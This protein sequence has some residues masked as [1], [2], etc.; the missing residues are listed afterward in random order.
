M[1]KYISLLL[2]ILFAGCSSKPE[3]IKNPQMLAL[4]NISV[5]L[6]IGGV[7]T[8]GSYQDKFL[9]KAPRDVY[10]NSFFIDKT[11]VT[12]AA[13]KQYL[14]ET[15]G[16]VRPLPHLEDPILGADKLPVVNV[17]HKE[18][19]DFCKFYNKRLP[20]EAEWEYAAKGN[21]KKTKY[22][23]G[24]DEDPIYMNYRGSKKFISVPVGSYAS[25]EYGLYDMN[26][27]VRE[28]VEDSYQKDF[29]NKPCTEPDLADLAGDIYDG[30]KGLFVK[31]K[32][33]EHNCYINPLNTADVIYKSNRGGSFEYSKG[34][35]ATISFRFF[36]EKESMH[37]DLGF[38]CVA[39]ESI[40]NEK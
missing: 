7:Y 21:T 35:P 34:Y 4:N 29:Y 31:S 6:I 19:Q 23:W 22:Y 13:Y 14:I 12:N 37:N 28:W 9:D 25:N 16:R 20:T 2:I 40:K 1:R 8:M 32:F 36:D 38:R 5:S 3:I 30:V 15:G 33:V 11:E 10:V 27:N 24:N 26:G 39:D 18:A 17:M